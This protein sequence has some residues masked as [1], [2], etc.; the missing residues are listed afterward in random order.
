MIVPEYKIDLMNKNNKVLK[1][2]E[3]L[4]KIS[5]KDKIIE[6]NIKDKAKGLELKS[7]QK[8]KLIKKK[9]SPKTLWVRRKKAS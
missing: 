6:K 2:F 9:Q 3:H 1:T 8:T 7:V 4:R 5:I